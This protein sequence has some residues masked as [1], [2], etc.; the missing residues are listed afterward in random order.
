MLLILHF[1]PDDCLHCF[2]LLPTFAEMKFRIACL[3]FLIIC[4]SVHAQEL[5]QYAPGFNFREGVY[6]NFEQFK[7]NNPIPKNAIVSRFNKSDSEFL[8]NILSAKNF[9]YRD[10]NDSLVTIDIPD[11]WGFARNGNIFVKIEDDFN[12]IAVL[13]NLSHFVASVTVF[14]NFNGPF[15]NPYYGPGGM[16]NVRQEMRQ[17]MLDFQ[18]GRTMEF[19]QQNL[20]MILQ[21]DR[22]LFEEYN[23]LKKSQ[24]RDMMF[25]YLRK[26]NEKHPIYFPERD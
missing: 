17:M 26:Y 3:F 15:Y 23:A 10:E 9:Q 24:K 6:L 1:S 18:T 5:V 16:P 19:T 21:R 22:K 14:N 12:R 8:P 11:V 4:V 2:D 7:N 20:E 25:L 13:G